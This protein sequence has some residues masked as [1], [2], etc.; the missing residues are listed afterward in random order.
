MQCAHARLATSTCKNH[1]ADLNYL[2]LHHN[3]PAKHGNMVGL[4]LSAE[5]F[6]KCARAQK[7]AR[8]GEWFTRVRA[9]RLFVRPMI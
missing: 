9:R 2:L 7:E 5:A 6:T 4:D 1:S 8:L 3:E